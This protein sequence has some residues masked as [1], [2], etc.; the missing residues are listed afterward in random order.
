M[1]ITPLGEDEF[2]RGPKQILESIS[3]TL[4]PFEE[5]FAAAIPERRILFPLTYR[6]E[7]AQFDV[8]V[9]AARA[10]GDDDLYV[11]AT[12]RATAVSGYGAQDP[13]VQDWLVSLDRRNDVESFDL[14]V[15]TAYYSARGA[16][17]LLISHEDHG[18]IGGRTDFMEIIRAHWPPSENPPVHYLVSSAHPPL[19]EGLT[20]EQSVTRLR[21]FSDETIPIESRPLEEQVYAFIE[22]WKWWRRTTGY[23]YEFVSP[24]LRHVYGD[25]EGDRILRASGWTD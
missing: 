2:Q 18:V 15:E 17:G 10:T 8:L 7:Q 4:D 14:S 16:W 19:Q 5:P 1:A 12:E 13:F 22:Y 24:L 9:R 11:S 21:E 23:D 25:E 3:L 6:L 20:I